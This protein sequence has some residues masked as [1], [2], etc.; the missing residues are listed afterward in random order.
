LNAT[1]VMGNGEGGFIP[2]GVSSM[3]QGAAT[4]FFA[5]VGFDTIACVGEFFHFTLFNLWI[6]VL[7]LTMD[8]LLQPKQRF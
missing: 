2:Y 3:M 8:N 5:F 1:E 7:S 6:I 4:C